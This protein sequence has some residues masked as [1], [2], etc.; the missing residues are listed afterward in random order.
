MTWRLHPRAWSLSRIPFPIFNYF[1]FHLYHRSLWLVSRLQQLG[2]NTTKMS[3]LLSIGNLS[4]PTL[5]IYGFF[6][7]PSETQTTYTSP[8]CDT[9]SLNSKQGLSF[10]PYGQSF[11]SY[12][13]KLEFTLQSSTRDKVE[14]DSFNIQNIYQCTFGK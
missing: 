9:H 8:P 14:I 6:F 10:P 5:L 13:V 1:C 12:P 11:Q 3:F 4:Y 7:D 2:P